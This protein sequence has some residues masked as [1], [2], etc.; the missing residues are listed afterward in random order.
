MG[1]AVWGAAHGAVGD[2][3][4][5][6]IRSNWP[7]I[8]GGQC[9]VG[10]S[11]YG[12]PSMTS[13]FQEVCN[14]KLPGDMG[15]RALAYQQ[16]AQSA[17][18]WWPHKDFVMVSDRPTEIHRDDRG[19]LHSEDGPAIVWSDGWGVYAVHGVRVPADVIH[20][21]DLLTVDRIRGERNV[22]VRRVMIERKGR[23]AFLRE[24]G[25]TVIHRDDWGTLWRVDLPGESLLVVEVV[26]STPEPDG[27]WKRY[28]LGVNPSDPQ[29]QTA[30]G[31]IAWTFQMLTK[32]YQQLAAQS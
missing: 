14:L 18:W 30:I 5:G 11:W 23:E 16:Q 10:W 22:E 4:R 8:V 20:R 2:A 7:K 29:C 32:E 17:G 9:W 6:H 12:S 26:N 1:G 15:D 3:V 28:M 31:A 27:T 25:A 19:R 21:P 13:F 24:A